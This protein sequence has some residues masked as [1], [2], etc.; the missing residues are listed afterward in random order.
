MKNGG[1]KMIDLN[2][3]SEEEKRLIRKAFGKIPSKQKEY[4]KEKNHTYYMNNQDRIK[5]KSKIHRGNNKDYY[6][7]YHQEHKKESKVWQNNKWR[8]DLKYKL[9]KAIR[10][11]INFSLKG[12]KEGKRWEDLVGY[13]VSDLIKHL[14]K[15][16]PK[17][18]NWNDYLEGKLH[19]DHIV[20]IS[21]FN[22][23]D[24]K[25][26]DFKR[27]WSLSNLQLL[28]ARENLIKNA[29]LYKPFQP[30]LKI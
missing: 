21:V 30:A 10:Y 24:Y 11:Q 20:P 13:S 6:I 15:T 26:I 29:K 3:L 5:E 16:M 12:N 7:K 18:Y 27:C 19:I 2:N 17:G 14:Q 22:Y 9:N 8:T 25:H 28:P 23:T 4:D 1:N